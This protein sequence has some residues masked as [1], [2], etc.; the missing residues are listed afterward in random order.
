MTTNA[1]INQQELENTPSCKLA[2]ALM[3]KNI[4]RGDTF[5]QKRCK[6]VHLSCLEKGP[7]LEDCDT[8]EEIFGVGKDIGYEYWHYYCDGFD[9]RGWGCG[10]RTLQTIASWIITRKSLPSSE[11]KDNETVEQSV[12]SISEI[13]RILVEDLKDKQKFS[14]FS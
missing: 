9:D 2:E 6:S 10:Y 5:F 14:R 7:C 13:Q 4:E 3:N 11:N 12:P 1:G 8:I